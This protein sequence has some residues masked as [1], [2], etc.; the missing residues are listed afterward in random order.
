MN[1]KTNDN[2]GLDDNTLD[3]SILNEKAQ[4]NCVLN[5]KM[6][7]ESVLKENVIDVVVLNRDDRV[8]DVNNIYD[9]DNWNKYM[10]QGERDLLVEKVPKELLPSII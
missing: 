7:D 3:D 4:I 1:E 5:D 10:Y 8:V 9:P 2:S 6:L